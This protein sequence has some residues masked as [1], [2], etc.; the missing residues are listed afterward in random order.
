MEEALQA[1]AKATGGDLTIQQIKKL[2]KDQ[3]EQNAG[4]YLYNLVGILVHEGVSNEGHY[5]SYIRDRGRN[6]Y[7]GGDGKSQVDGASGSSSNSNGS[8]A[9]FMEGLERGVSVGSDGVEEG[10]WFKFNDHMVTPFDPREIE[11]TC[12][13][14]VAV[15][16]SGVSTT[17]EHERTSNAF[18][19]FYEK[20]VPREESITGDGSAEGG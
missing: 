8:G 7:Q 2:H 20:A 1:A 11:T 9:G 16:T 3:M 15:S 19:L 14:G 18:L 10:S 6:A 13:G 5:Y 4:N 17:V 12:F